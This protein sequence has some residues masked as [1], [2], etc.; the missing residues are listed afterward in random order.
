MQLGISTLIPSIA[1]FT[2]AVLLVFV[3]MSRPLTPA[4]SAFRVYLLT[5]FMW[6]IFALIVVRG[7]GNQT[8]WFRLMTVAIS[9]VP[10][11][12][13]NFVQV[14]INKPRKWA[15]W[16]YVYGL[17]LIPIT[18]FTPWMVISARVDAT[19]IYYEFSYPLITLAAIIGYALYV[20]CLVDLNRVFRLTDDPVQRN[21]LQYLMV[22]LWIIIITSLV[23]FYPPLGKYPI[24]VAGTAIAALVLTY[25]VLR[26]QLLDIQVVIRKSL[27]YTIPTTI[28][29]AAYFLIITLAIR[30]FEAF[31]STEILLTSL[32][33]AILSAIIVQPL[34]DRAQAWVDKLFF[35]EKYD[36]NLMLQRVSRNATSF[37]EIDLLANMILDEIVST[38]HIEKAAFFL[39]D[40]PSKEYRLITHRYLGKNANIRLRPE[41]PI[42]TRLKDSEGAVSK[43]DFANIS[44]SNSQWGLEKKLLDEME[45][46]LYVP[47]RVQESLIGFL[48]IG[49]KRSEQPYTQDDQLTVITLANQ[50][51]VA[52]ENA[53]L[54]AVEQTRRK[55]MDSLYTL[56]REL[57]AT[58]AIRTVLE[59]VV[60]HAL[61]SIHVTFSRILIRGED[62]SFVCQAVHPVFGLDY[63]LRLGQRDPRILYPYYEQSFSSD[64]PIVLDRTN[65]SLN[66]DEKKALYLEHV[67]SLCICPLRIGGVPIGILLLGER[68]HANREPFDSDKLR[69]ATAIAD[70]ASNAIQRARLHDQLEESFVQTVVA[71][72]NTIDARDSYT[73]DHSERL[74]RLATDTASELGCSVDEIQAIHWAM[75]LHDIGKIGTPDEILQKAGPLSNEEWELI[76]K[77]PVIGADIIAP[78]KRLKDVAPIIRAHHER[79]DG[80]GYPR[81]LK[82]DQIPLG[83]RIVA[84]VDSYGAITD[85]RVYRKARTH[86]EAIVE[87]R[88]CMNSQ[89]DPLVAKAFIKV[90]EKYQQEIKLKHSIPSVAGQ[91]D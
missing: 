22:G 77:H 55:E 60:E 20:F 83:A 15:R 75:Q 10:L 43:R 26:H 82:G 40:N 65:T 89:F 84:V 14:N 39:Q 74:A 63:D 70:Q 47:L 54:Y 37:L 91:N 33:V 62:S 88:R 56:S 58:D 53:R 46:E 23:N 12:I 36:S 9:I 13:F 42:I 90:V 17:I 4:K 61:E 6:V 3:T 64:E 41:H 57:V 48:A 30:T 49:Q 81:K 66:D 38:L 59:R 2:Y 45:A 28:I 16:I 73:S 11:S 32:L 80:T 44:Q 71:L 87:I 18:I 31:T 34:R 69:L 51:A 52:I 35:R 78:V 5:M 72:A 79:Y 29:G 50:T 24:D 8:L 68:R 21:R 85:N 19:G 76:R 7:W 27:I 1:I 86:E 67:Q 25:A